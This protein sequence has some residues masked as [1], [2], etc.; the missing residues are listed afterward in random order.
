V[1]V[2][3]FSVILFSTNRLIN[4]AEA[5]EEARKELKTQLFHAAKLVSV[6]ELAAGIA[7]E[8]NNPLAIISS[9]CG[10]IRDMF[11][12]EVGGD[13]HM[14]PETP[15]NIVNEL[16]IVDEA[17]NR[18]KDIT[19]KLLKSARKSEPRLEK[20]NVNQILDD[21]V[22]GLIEKEFQVANIELV[23]DYDSHLPK[24]LL[25]P[26]QI[27]QV[28]QNLVNNAGD[29]IEDSGQVTLSTR[30]KDENIQVVV[31]DTGKGI[32]HEQMGKIFLPFFTTKEVGKGTGLGLGISLS[33]VESMGGDIDVQSMPDAG[34]SFIVSLPINFKEV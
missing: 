5:N 25:D 7:H 16:D 22:D 3:I 4:R 20:C 23:K 21:V 34:S 2:A 6:G 29:A 13:A 9:Q 12:P 10:V 17:V 11:D 31:S 27:Y 32:A 30:I 8:I 24:I 28:F 1:V 26:D 33:I 15:D 14:K 18:A 19:R